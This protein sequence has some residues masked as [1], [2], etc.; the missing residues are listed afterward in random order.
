MGAMQRR[1]RKLR[2]RVISYSAAPFFALLAVLLLQTGDGAGRIVGVV[3][4]ILA[5]FAI[6]AP[7]LRASRR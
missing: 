6:L 3:L 2:W 5:V 1:R 4:A 7:L